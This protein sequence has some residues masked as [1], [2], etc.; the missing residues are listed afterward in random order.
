MIS[1]LDALA[2]WP[3]SKKDKKYLDQA[4]A[5]L[6]LTNNELRFVVSLRELIKDLDLD[7]SNIEV[8]RLH[9]IIKV[10]ISR[11]RG[12]PKGSRSMWKNGPANT[13]AGERKRRYRD[14]SYQ[15]MQMRVGDIP[16]YPEAGQKIPD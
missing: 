11:P 1:L 3:A 8:D 13:P 10:L 7:A 6:R 16:D 5:D 12:R 2:G 4:V 9:E 15:L 14:P